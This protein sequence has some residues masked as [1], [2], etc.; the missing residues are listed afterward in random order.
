MLIFPGPSFLTVGEERH[1]YGMGKGEKDGGFEL[2][3][4]SVNT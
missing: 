2:E 4:V 1:K 3:G